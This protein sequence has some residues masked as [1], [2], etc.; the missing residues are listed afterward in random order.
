MTGRALVLG[1]GGEPAR[2]WELGLLSGLADRGIALRNADLLVGTSAGALLGAQLGCGADLEQLYRQ[3]VGTAPAG[4]SGSVGG[5]APVCEPAPTGQPVRARRSGWLALRLRFQ[6]RH[7]RDP[8]H[9]RTRV[10]RLAMSAQTPP[11]AEWVASVRSRLP[12]CD[13]PAQRLLIGAV[14]GGSGEFVAFDRDSGVP[15]VDALAAGS[16]APGVWPPVELHGRYWVDGCVR[17]A[18][19]AD[20]AAGSD[21]VVVLAPDPRGCGRIAGAVEQ[22]AR[23]RAAARVVLLVPGPVARHAMGRGAQDPGRRS[24]AARLARAARAG[25]AEADAVLAEVAEVWAD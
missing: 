1:G 11:V 7:Y 19:N 18:T 16:A 23:L 10:G 22:V 8:V 24:S 17:S 9:Y 3:E 6:A 25:R 15:L 20:L 21:R 12:G 4:E 13:W 2:A 5:P 14:D